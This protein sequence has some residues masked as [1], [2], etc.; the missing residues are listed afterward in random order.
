MQYNLQEAIDILSRT[1]KALSNLLKD[2]PD[3]W[4]KNNEG[5]E[6]WSP[7]DVMGH[8][9]HG[10]KTDWITRLE[11]ILG[12]NDNKTFE[13]FDRFA[14]FEDSK[15]KN[16]NDL[17]IEFQELRSKNLEILK[18]KNIQE[19]DLSKKGIHPDF[20]DVT[21]KELLSVWV[22]HDLGHIAQI[23]RVMAKQYKENVGPWKA[24]LR[25]VND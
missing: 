7:F 5:G 13:P 17:L 19:S 8:Y 9:V 1:P 11:I 18:S 15:G 23:T 16:I 4:T 20:G 25:V 10:E 3:N 14:Q 21:L 12:E 2:L 24:Y 22:A 6:S